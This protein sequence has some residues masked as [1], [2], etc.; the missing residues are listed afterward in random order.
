MVIDAVTVN[1]WLL[2]AAERVNPRI[3]PPDVISV[4][5]ATFPCLRKAYYDRTRRRLPT[6]VEALKT[7]GSE[8]HRMI[9]DVLREEGWEVEVSVSLPVDGF[10]LVGRVDALNGEAVIEIK[11][12]G[13]VRKSLLG[14]HR[15]QLQAYLNMLP[16]RKGYL[17]YVDR[18]SGRVKVFQVVRDKSALRTVVGRARQLYEALRANIP[19]PPSRG[20]WCEVCPWKWVCWSGGDA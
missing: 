11:T 15:L 14:S 16:V 17:I 6:P 8:I 7:V 20:P 18:S 12:S 9:Q 5:E 1:R 19:P 10:R 13:G 2:R 3:F 4:T